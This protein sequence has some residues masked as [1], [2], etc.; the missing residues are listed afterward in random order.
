MPGLNLL[1]IVVFFQ[2]RLRAV[3]TWLVPLAGACTFAMTSASM[4]EKDAVQALYAAA[5]IALS[6]IA[7]N[8]SAMNELH[9]RAKWLAERQVERVSG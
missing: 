2:L 3:F 1:S 4:P 9:L 5:Y 6:Y 7:W 8:G